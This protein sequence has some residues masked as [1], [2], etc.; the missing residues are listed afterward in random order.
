MRA[1]AAACSPA[2]ERA[3]ATAWLQS[4]SDIG[5]SAGKQCRCNLC[6][7]CWWL[8]EHQSRPAACCPQGVPRTAAQC[9]APG[10]ASAAKPP[11]VTCCITVQRC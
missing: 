9:A 8:R 2:L 1:N 10:A 7:R 3:A 5:S 11:A 4:V 6:T